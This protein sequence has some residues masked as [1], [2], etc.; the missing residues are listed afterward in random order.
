MALDVVIG[1]LKCSVAG[2]NLISG[3]GAGIKSRCNGKRLCGGT[4]LIGVADT[5]ILPKIVQIDVYLLGSHLIEHF[6][7]DDVGTLS[8]FDISRGIGDRFIIL[9]SDE[10]C[11]VH[12]ITGIVV[13]E[14][15]HCD[16]LAG[17]DS[18]DDAADVFGTVTLTVIIGILLVE[19]AY[20]LF[21]DA[22]NGRI[23]G[24]MESITVD[25]GFDGPLESRIFRLISVLSSVRSCQDRLIILFES[26]HPAGIGVAGGIAE[27]RRSKGSHGIDPLIFRLKCD[28]ANIGII[29]LHGQKFAYLT[30]GKSLCKD[31]VMTA[32]VVYDKIPEFGDIDIGET[33]CKSI[34]SG[35][36]ISVIVISHHNGCIDDHVIDLLAGREDRT[37]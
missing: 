32:L 8:V 34:E 3:D 35:I 11:G 12:V 1:N 28:S 15:S 5:L 10:G 2:I 17:I 20:L 13:R 23:Y 33:C 24:C 30:V 29:F 37:L 26:V 16:Y 25:S 21:Y 27:H 22:L 31:P 18:H 36:K 19:F 14:I 4:G 9:A 7:C 6:L